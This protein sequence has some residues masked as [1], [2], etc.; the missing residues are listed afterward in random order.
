MLQVDSFTYGFK[1]FKAVSMIF[2]LSDVVTNAFHM[3]KKN[4]VQT[5]A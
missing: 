4:V 3:I 2:K 5:A 1:P